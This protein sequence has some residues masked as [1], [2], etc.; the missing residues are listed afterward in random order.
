ML[1]KF[2]LILILFAAGHAFAQT[3][4]LIDSF[5][6]KKISIQK[7]IPKPIVKKD[8]PAKKISAPI[9]SHDTLKSNL[10]AD[11]LASQIDS[12]KNSLKD[13]IKIDSLKSSLTDKQRKQAKHPDWQQ[14][15]GFAKLFKINFNKK[16]N[17]IFLAE[18][19]R[20]P[21]TK[22]F[23]F[24]SLAGIVFFLAFIK[25]SFPKYFINIF[26]LFFQ[27]SLRQ[28]Q[29]REVKLQDNLPSLLTNILFFLSAGMF[30]ALAAN[31]YYLITITFPLLFIYCTSVIAFIYLFKFLFLLFS[32]WI[33]R[34]DDAAENYISIVFLV[35][36]V[37]GIVI[38]PLLLLFAFSSEI[39]SEIIL[40]IIISIFIL[41]L[42]YRYI[43][44][45]P[46]LRSRCKINPFHFFIYLCAVEIIPMFVIYKVLSSRFN[47]VF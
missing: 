5:L 39:V 19:A 13:S 46:F 8:S 3:D 32:G 18:E 23:I 38:I 15:T 45:I 41:L 26:R 29:N 34:A 7:I 35:N 33:F 25:V 44:A 40:T 11:S 30:L 12:T 36:K 6:N 17:Q 10:H 9:V 28:K 20:Q 14:D 31:K 21:K 42:L 2:L 47:G 37:A 16:T 27:T 43:T 22:D 1:K 4:S 24:Y